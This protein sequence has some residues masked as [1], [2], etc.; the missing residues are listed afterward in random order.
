MNNE[1]EP[2]QK[3]QENSTGEWGRFL[4]HTSTTQTMNE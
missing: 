4:S 1:P 3:R 2:E